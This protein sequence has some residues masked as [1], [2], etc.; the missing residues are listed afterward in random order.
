[1]AQEMAQQD[2]S[3]FLSANTLIGEHVINNKGVMLGKV[4]DVM[5][6]LQRG[7]VCYFVLSFGGF[8]GMGNKLFAIPVGLIRLVD[9]GKKLMLDIDKSTLEKAPG[10]DKNNWPDF[11]NRQWEEDIKKYYG[12]SPLWQ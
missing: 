1:M 12:K 6:D 9:D 7:R 11:S 10:F 5:V 4:E 3:Y 2:N 8:L